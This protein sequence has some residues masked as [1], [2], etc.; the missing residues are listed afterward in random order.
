M[1]TDLIYQCPICG[2]FEWLEGGRCVSCQAHV[3]IISRSLI[4]INGDTQP[5]SHWYRKIRSFNLPSG[6]S[7]TIMKSA[8]VRLS[9]E[10]QKGIYRGFAGITAIHFIR[11]PVDTGTVS[12]NETSLFF[13]GKTSTIEVPV[14]K[15]TSLTIESNTVIVISRE[16]GTLFFDFLEES[17]KKWEDCIQKALQ[18]HHAP[19]EIVEFYPRIRLSSALRK[20]PSP[21]KGHMPLRMPVRK[22]YTRDHSTFFTVLRILVRPLIKRLFSV[23]ITGLENIPAQGP[24]IVMPNHTSFLDSIILGVFPKRYIWFM[25]K[26]SEYRHSILYWFLRLANSF[27]VRRYTN[28]VQAVRNAIRI[29]QQGH[30]LGIFPEGER[31]WDGELLPVRYGAIRLILAFGVPVIPVGITGAYEL[32]PR[33]TSSIK[34]IPVSITIGEPLQFEHISIPKQTHRD[35]ESAST[36]LRSEMKRLLGGKL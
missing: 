3:S 22:W 24:A 34:R 18:R 11:Q 2:S 12:L 25:A 29:V 13:S 7:C 20:N 32:M 8:Q 31:T 16:H 28:D 6:T 27:P 9:R 30:I 33:W 17:G 35:I 36:L 21:T 26:N 4:S 15:I 1:I 14:Q 23:T 5:I 10:A 19:D